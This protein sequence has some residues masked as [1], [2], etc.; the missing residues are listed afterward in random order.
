MV[1]ISFPR[2]LVGIGFYRLCRF[3]HSSISCITST[4]GRSSALFSRGL[5]SLLLSLPCLLRSLQQWDRRARTVT[6]P[7]QAVTT[8]YTFFS[9]GPVRVEDGTSSS[10]SRAQTFLHVHLWSKVNSQLVSSFVILSLAL[11]LFS[12]QNSLTIV[13]RLVWLWMCRADG[14]FVCFIH[15]LNPSFV[16]FTSD[17]FLHTNLKVFTWFFYFS[18]F[19]YSDIIT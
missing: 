11:V 15:Q 19:T 6:D 1:V 14:A 16:Q 7:A 5:R 2:W 13:L 9:S 17:P 18:I 4:L 3:R 12:L 8:I 10:V